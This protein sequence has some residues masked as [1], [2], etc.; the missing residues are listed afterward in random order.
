[1]RLAVVLYSIG[2]I[3]IAIAVGRYLGRRDRA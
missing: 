3:P 2:V 1:M